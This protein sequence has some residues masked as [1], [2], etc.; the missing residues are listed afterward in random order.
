ME[1]Q[2]MRSYAVIPPIMYDSTMKPP[3]KYDNRNG[4]IEDPFLLY[5]EVENI[6][7]WTEGENRVADC[8]QYY[9][10]S[11]KKEKYKELLKK[12]ANKRTRA[13]AKQQQAANAHS[14]HRNSKPMMKDAPEKGG[15][16][17]SYVGKTAS[18][19]SVILS[20]ATPLDHHSQSVKVKSENEGTRRLKGEPNE[21]GDAKM[22]PFT[23]APFHGLIPGQGILSSAKGERFMMEQRKRFDHMAAAAAAAAVEPLQVAGTAPPRSRLQ[24]I[25]FEPFSSEHFERELRQMDFS[26]RVLAEHE[27]LLK[28]GR[29][30][31]H[32]SFGG[33]GQPMIN[34]M[35][36][37]A[38]SVSLEQMDEA[39]KLFSA[40][41]QK[42]SAHQRNNSSGSGQ[43]TAPNLI[44][45]IITRQ[46][47]TDSSGSTKGNAPPSST[48]ATSLASG[49][50]ATTSSVPPQ[51]V[52]G[53]SGSLGNFSISRFRSGLEGGGG[54]GGGQPSLAPPV[55][56]TGLK[57]PSRPS[58]TSS[59]HSSQSSSVIKVD[60]EAEEKLAKQGPI[61]FSKV[62]PPTS[63][64]AAA[65]AAA[66]A[67]SSV[68]A[69]SLRETIFNV[70][71][72]NFSGSPSAMDS[73]KTTATSAATTSSTSASAAHQA[74]LDSSSM[75]TSY[76][77]DKLR[78]ALQTGEGS[79]H[80]LVD[81]SSEQ[82]GPPAKR[83]A[84]AG[85][86]NQQL[87]QQVIQMA[88]SSQQPPTTTTTPTSSS[89]SRPSLGA[90]SPPSESNASNHSSSSTTAAATVTAATHW[91]PVQQPTTSSTTSAPS[92][93]AGM[94]SSSSSSNPSSPWTSMPTI[95]LFGMG[96]NPS[97][98][99]P[100]VTMPSS[101]SAAVTSGSGAFANFFQ[102]RIEEAMRV[103][104]AGGSS[105][106]SR[107]RA[108]S[109]KS[110]TTSAEAT[111]DTR[112]PEAQK[113]AP[114]L[115]RE[116]Y[117]DSPSSPPEMVIDE[118][119]ASS[120]DII[121]P[122]SAPP[123][124]AAQQSSS[125]TSG[126]GAPSFSET[127][128]PEQSSNDQSSSSRPSTPGQS[129][130]T[131]GVI[132]KLDTVDTDANPKE[133]PSVGPTSSLTTNSNHSMPTSAVSGPTQVLAQPQYEALSDDDD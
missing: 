89:A 96:G 94:S 69:G 67:G 92:V 99:S 88:G 61:D 1:A 27:E 80:H 102:N 81:A 120:P 93:S 79:K 37:S 91:P 116:A 53:G 10:H 60:G 20:Y 124:P 76:S 82:R 125:S 121:K 113:T 117:P 30:S 77:I 110:V 68:P 39:S 45:A 84:H 17:K 51:T 57:L 14:A 52:T 112:T 46:I 7:I 43:M 90:V 83:Y 119:R 40:S 101:A 126:S 58:S 62:L 15:T 48:T 132:K 85:D 32:S 109:P 9:Y 95:S 108:G 59:G 71:S 4:F 3:V 129:S 16:L 106:A 103:T 13:L 87:R 75:S 86:I 115:V 42:D 131:S 70:I 50:T 44:D 29:L 36:P 73:K 38:G 54:S 56:T 11:K 122:V 65:A 97:A 2:K 26:G 41:F 19:T 49:T 8:V 98:N 64:S 104:E 105:S 107:S 111:R 130:A 123:S 5:K 118:N 72:N 34:P 128:K 12:H 114:N 18:A 28:G 21:A 6:N 25:G 78:K 47:N 74:N 66:V 33:G 24:A 23:Q 133:G 55:T 63:A 35:K 22:S 100:N 127:K 31:S